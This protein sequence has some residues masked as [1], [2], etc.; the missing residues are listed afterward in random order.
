MA[1][2][3]PRRQVP[4]DTEEILSL[5]QSSLDVI[6]PYLK[7]LITG[8]VTLALVLLGWG[9]YSYLKHS[10]ETRAQAALDQMRPRLSQ[11]EQAAEAIKALNTL[12]QDYPST[13]A[14]EIARLFKAHLL[15][16]TKKF[17]EATRMYEELR[18]SLGNNDPHGWGRFVA[19]SLSYCYEAQGE[20]A[21][22]AQVLKPLAAQARGNYQ[23]VL[24]ARLGMLYD[25]AGN[26]QEASQTWQQL[27]KQTQNPA[28]VSYWKERLA[29]VG[30]EPPKA[31]K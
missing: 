13:N 26:H 2:K 28:L 7:W 14:A 18:A 29:G 10:R 5:A 31:G 19:E 17:P 1:R 6:R 4:Q 27:L 23:T 15:Y 25:K 20:W 24:L 12:I 9:G 8:S 21:R 30:A 16:Q 3:K 11:P 22:A